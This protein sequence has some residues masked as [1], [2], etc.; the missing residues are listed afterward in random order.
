MFCLYIGV[1]HTIQLFTNKY[2]EQKTPK[3]SVFDD[4][5]VD[6]FQAICHKTF[7]FLS[8]IELAESFR[9]IPVSI[10]VAKQNSSYRPN[11]LFVSRVSHVVPHGLSWLKVTTKIESL[12]R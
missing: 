7:I 12:P 2:L 11:S 10:C 8:S 5:F 4:D 1:K 3:N 9:T 6:C